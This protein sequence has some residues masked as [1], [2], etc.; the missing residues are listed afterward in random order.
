MQHATSQWESIPNMMRKDV[1]IGFAI[2]G[3]LV[4]VLVVYVLAVSGKKNANTGA[5]LAEG[6]PADVSESA[7][8]KPANPNDPFKNP[9]QPV[10]S[11]DKGAAPADKSQANGTEEDK[12][13]MALSKGTVPM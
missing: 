4:A 9:E 8:A 11:A 3:I 13:V 12:W 2:G 1:Q 7:P 5:Q 6:S 10:A